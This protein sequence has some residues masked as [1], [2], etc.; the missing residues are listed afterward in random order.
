MNKMA[1]MQNLQQELK[2]GFLLCLGVS[3]QNLIVLFVSTGARFVARPNDCYSL[4]HGSMLVRLD[5]S[6]KDGIV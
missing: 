1:K 2:Y 5:L 4:G 3:M 6:E